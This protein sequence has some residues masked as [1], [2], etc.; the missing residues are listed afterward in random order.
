MQHTVSIGVW[1]GTLKLS[2]V[3]LFCSLRK[4]ENEACPRLNHGEMFWTQNF[5]KIIER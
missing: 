4:Y 1:Y 2:V 3:L 5:P